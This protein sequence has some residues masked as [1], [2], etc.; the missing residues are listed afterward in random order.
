MFIINHFRKYA[1]I[2]YLTEKSVYTE[3]WLMM[4][5]CG[6]HCLNRTSIAAPC[7]LA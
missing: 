2:H 3:K 1:C 7:Y 5:K 4:S 6:G